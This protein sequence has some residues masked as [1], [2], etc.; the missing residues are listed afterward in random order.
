M[1]SLLKKDEAGFSFVELMV[2]IALIGILSAIAAP[3]F[4]RS[5]PQKRL[6]AAART[7][8]ADMQR[9]RMSAVRRNSKVPV[10]FVG[11]ADEQ[12]YFFDTNN[13]KNFS[14]GEFKRNLK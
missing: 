11:G 12:Y 14:A 13:D 8:Y 9:A 10:R 1:R 3:N 2:V 5:L 7:L 6:K 4:L